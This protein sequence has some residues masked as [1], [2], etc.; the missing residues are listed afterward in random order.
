MAKQSQSRS[1]VTLRMTRKR[2]LELGLL[3]C[4]CGWP[5]N[6]HFDHGSRPC[7]HS[8]CKAYRERG[9]SGTTV[10]SEQGRNEV[11]D[12]AIAAIPDP[13]GFDVEFVRNRLRALKRPAER[14]EQ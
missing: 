11:L 12:E 14:K 1:D 6:N 5:E 10:V 9:V 3:I 2:A 8:T 13:L 7:A 4:E